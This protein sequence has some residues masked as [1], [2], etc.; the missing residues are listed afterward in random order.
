MNSNQPLVWLYLSGEGSRFRV[1]EVAY[2]AAEG[3]LGARPI[4][5][6]VKQ[7]DP[8]GSSAGAALEEP[9]DE[10]VQKAKPN[11]PTIG[12]ADMLAHSKPAEGG[13]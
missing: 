8:F 7:S 4:V 5:S 6:D 12:G 1:D 13:A 9:Y 10:H 3:R 11:A 2:F